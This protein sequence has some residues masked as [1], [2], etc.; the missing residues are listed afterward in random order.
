MPPFDVFNPVLRVIDDI[1]QT[2]PMQVTT[3]IPHN[4]ATGVFVRLLVP[5]IYG[6]V[7]ANNLTGYIVVT[8][9]TTF[10]FPINS[11]NF[12]AFIVPLNPTPLQRQEVPQVVVAGSTNELADTQ[13]RN[14]L[15]PQ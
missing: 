7:Q 10:D 11:T 5:K 8:G 14:I 6:M 1:S 13:Y 2:N 15:P 9:P 3:T 4:Y 12:T